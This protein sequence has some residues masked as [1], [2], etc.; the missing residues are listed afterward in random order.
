MS[1]RHLPEEDDEFF[2]SKSDQKRSVDRLQALGE[3][4]AELNVKQL[5]QLPIDE[6]LLKA[7]LDMKKIKAHEALRRHKQFIGKLMRHA[8]EAAL[9]AAM[10]PMKSPALQRQLDLIQERLLQQGDAYIGEV[11]AKFPA[12]DRH[13]L[14]QYVRQ[15]QQEQV[16]LAAAKEAAYL[17]AEATVK[18]T[19]PAETS[20]TD[21]A[22]QLTPAQH[23]LWLHLRELAAINS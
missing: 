6:M 15:A 9:L 18:N 11:L 21:S 19:K 13:T 4:L 16:K 10:H 22:E 2:I 17:A 5:K 7:F 14:R 23:R 3:R 20:E 8:D 12:A 1:L